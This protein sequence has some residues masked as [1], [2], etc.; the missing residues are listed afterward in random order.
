MA[1]I[2]CKASR[3]QHNPWEW[4][5]VTFREVPD[6]TPRTVTIRNSREGL[7]GK[8]LVFELNRRGY[9]VYEIIKRE[10]LT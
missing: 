3:H 4:L 5:R 7:L 10:A 1:T 2:N 8:E 9:H 6:A